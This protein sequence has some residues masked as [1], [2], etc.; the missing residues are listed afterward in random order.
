MIQPKVPQIIT[1]FCQAETE[2]DVV[3]VG[4]GHVLQTE[5][6]EFVVDLGIRVL[7]DV[8]LTLEYPQAMGKASG[9]GGVGRF[10]LTCPND[11]DPYGAATPLDYDFYKIEKGGS[12]SLNH[13]GYS[14]GPRG[15]W[16]V[17]G[18][19][20]GSYDGT[21]D[22]SWHGE[23]DSI[24]ITPSE[25]ITLW[26]NP[27]PRT[28]SYAPAYRFDRSDFLTKLPDEGRHSNAA[29]I[30]FLDGHAKAVPVAEL[31][32]KLK[33]VRWDHSTD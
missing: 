3:A 12:Y 6:V 16:S 31:H 20:R 18:G 33:W 24:V 28:A 17:M 13:D 22:A 30:L 19:S 23:R 32:T 27:A 5:F 29:N 21:D 14:R 1:I 2:V 10:L 15:G 11:A 7:E 26:D 4:I 8:F 9:D 25:Y